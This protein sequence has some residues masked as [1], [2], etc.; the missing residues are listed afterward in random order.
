[1]K[2]LKGRLHIQF[3]DLM[4]GET[5][6]FDGKPH[7]KMGLGG[8]GKPEI[9]KEKLKNDLNYLNGV[10]LE[11]GVK[12]HYPND[13]RVEKTDLGVTGMDVIED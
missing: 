7:M 9:I 4:P 2:V 12:Y 10:D 6:V 3:G 13:K 8:G 5:F 11:T 1:M